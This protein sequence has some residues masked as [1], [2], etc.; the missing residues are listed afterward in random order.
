M[1]LGKLDGHMLK[2]KKLD[3]SLAPY[4][5]ISSK[6]IKDLDVRP[7]T[8]KL[9]EEN[10]GRTLSD[11]NHRNIFFDSSPR[12]IEIKAK[13]NK[14]DLKLK[15]FGTAKETINKTK[16]QPTDWEKIFTNDVTDKGLV[17]KIYKQLMM[18][19]SIQTNHQ[20]NNALKTQAEDL[21]RHFSQEGIQMANRHMK[22]CSTSLVIRR[23]QIKTRVR[24][25]LTPVRMA[26]IKNPQTTNAG[27]GVERRECSSTVGGNINW[28]SHHGE[29]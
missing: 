19:N 1:V 23:M 2:K 4:T 13:I 29:L 14:W 18:L 12:R 17:S 22:R 10:M 6:W 27:E 20:Q 8:I 24:Y 28:Y 5:K 26:I 3:H 21:N 15:S 25:Q 11:I 9:R 7:D 16:R